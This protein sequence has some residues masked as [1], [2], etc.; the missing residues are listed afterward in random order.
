M[1][2]RINRD[3]RRLCRVAWAL[4]GRGEIGPGIVARTGRDMQREFFDPPDLSRGNDQS[5]WR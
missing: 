3:R 2:P 1:T 5:K 4:A